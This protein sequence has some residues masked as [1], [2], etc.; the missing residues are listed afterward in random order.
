MTILQAEDGFA[1]HLAMIC[2]LRLLKLYHYLPFVVV[3]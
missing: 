3:V 2:K 1:T